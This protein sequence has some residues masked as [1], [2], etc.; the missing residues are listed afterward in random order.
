VKVKVKVKVKASG[1]PTFLDHNHNTQQA[2][3]SGILLFC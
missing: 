1:F 3:S 2:G